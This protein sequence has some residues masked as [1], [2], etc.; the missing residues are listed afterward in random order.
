MTENTP[1]NIDD[2]VIPDNPVEGSAF[3]AWGGT[4][5][6]E[7][8]PPAA[9]DDLG[10]PIEP[11]ES[12]GTPKP[13][14]SPRKD[15]L[16]EEDEEEAGQE[17]GSATPDEDDTVFYKGV[18]DILHK[19]GFF[20]DADNLDDITDPTKLAELFD[21]E[22]KARLNDRQKEI[23]EYMNQGVPIDKVTK[24]QTALQEAKSITPQQVQEDEQLAMNLL[25][26]DYI[27]KG[28]DEVTSKRYIEMLK[29]SGSLESEALIALENRKKTLETMHSQEITNAKEQKRLEEEKALEEAKKLKEKLSSNEVFGRKV[30]PVTIEKLIKIAETPVA[31]T[32]SGEPVNAIMKYRLDNPIDFEHKLTY[33]YAVTDGF[34]SLDVF[35]RSAESRLSREFRNSISSLSSSDP[36]TTQSVKSSKGTTIDINTIDDIV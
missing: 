22:V 9:T 16:E 13:S 11:D 31:Y 10:N 18:A 25:Y 30:S 4:P 17:G 19:Q 1:L 15:P 7:E 2:V 32:K 5:P 6:V 26:S 29:A 21:K 33:L 36:I 34:K 27:H 23:L 20:Q 24:I 8:T 12:G 14:F 28:F 3:P 35:D